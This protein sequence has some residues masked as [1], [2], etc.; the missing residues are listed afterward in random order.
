MEGVG[1]TRVRRRPGLARGEAAACRTFAEAVLV[2]P[3]DLREELLAILC[4][5]FIAHFA[6]ALDS[7]EERAVCT[8]K[9]RLVVSPRCPYRHV[10]V[11]RI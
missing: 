3:G 9:L 10:S 11:P 4:R 5:A 7:P 1:W 6:C 8:A 2:Q